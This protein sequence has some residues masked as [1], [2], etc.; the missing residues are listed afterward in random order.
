MPDSRRPAF[1]PAPSSRSAAAARAPAASR[2][3]ALRRA[4]CVLWSYTWSLAFDAHWSLR[5][6]VTSS[7]FSSHMWKICTGSRVPASASRVRADAVL[8]STGGKVHVT[9][10]RPFAFDTSGVPSSKS[11]DG[12]RAARMLRECVDERRI[13]RVVVFHRFSYSRTCESRRS[14]FVGYRFGAYDA[15]LI[16]RSHA[17]VYCMCMRSR[18]PAA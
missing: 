12:R 14:S 15:Q 2:A 1:W 6:A 7:G 9:I 10:P 5:S 17:H 18:A 3:S 11:G 8:R 16:T 13:S 4:M